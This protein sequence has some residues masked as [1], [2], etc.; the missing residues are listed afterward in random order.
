MDTELLS[1]LF[2]AFLFIGVIVAFR[3]RGQINELVQKVMHLESLLDL[4]TK[5]IEGLKQKIKELTSSQVVSTSF[6]QEALAEE[7]EPS[8]EKQK[9]SA[10]KQAPQTETLKEQKTV[11]E[12]KDTPLQ[13]TTPESENNEHSNP[14]KNRAAMHAKSEREERLIQ[15][16][17]EYRQDSKP[18]LFDFDTLVKGNG[19]FWLGAIVLAIG[20]VFLAKYSIEA[21]LL[22]PIVRVVLGAIFGCSLVVVAEVLNQNKEKFKI[23]T[24]YI[25]AALASGGVIT[26][27]AMILVS[28]DFYDFITPNI[29]FALLAIVSIAATY[30]ALRFGPVL[31]AIGIIGAYAV[32][33]LVST[34]SNNVIA[35][36]T[37]V[38][39]VS[40][41]AV[42]VAQLVKQKWLWWQSFVGH[43]V[44]FFA[45]V[46]MGGKDDFSIVLLY[47]LFS[48]YLFAL[49]SILGWKL[50]QTVELALSLKEL[51]A[52]KKELVTIIATLLLMAVN[53]SIHQEFT[54]IV[55][56]SLV[57]S[58]VIM[59]AT[60]RH[61]DLDHWPYLALGF[62]IFGFNLFS[63]YIDFSDNLFP[64]SGKYL[65]IQLSVLIAM[66]FSLQMIKRYPQRHAFLLLL[67][68]AP[69]SL[70]GV[71]YI[72]A[73]PSAEQFLYPVW[74]LEMLLIAIVASYSAMKTQTKL[75]QVTYL[76]LANAMLTMC[77][78]MLLSASTLTLALAVQVA[79]MS[80]LS[81]KYKV[82]LPDWLYKVALLVVVTRLTLAP[83]LAEYK[84]EF[85]FSVHWTLIV[86][87]AVLTVIWLATKYNPS[88]QLNTWFKGVL[89]HI[90][91]L[92]VTTETS[93]VLT[94]SY[95]DF[96][97]LAYH[98]AVLLALNWL[99]LSA[100]YFWRSRLSVSM[101]PLY[102][103]AGKALFV[104][105]ALIHFDISLV[106]SPF[107]YQHFVGD[108]MVNWLIPQWVL[109]VVVLLS[110]FKFEL[111]ETKYEK[112]I[113]AIAAT[114]SFF[115]INGEIRNVFNQGYLFWQ[116]PMQQAE[117][118]TYSIVW[119]L[120]STIVIYIGQKFEK[121]KLTNLGFIVL[122]L[123]VLK[124]FSVDMSHLEGLLR[125]LSFIGL[126]LALVAIGWLFQKMKVRS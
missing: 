121:S 120:V 28:F 39:F 14:W 40:L 107:I 33:I 112:A 76:V 78:T 4:K 44:W 52:P 77:L 61:R 114:F 122:A 72:M 104:G 21:G 3:G 31:A 94:G 6:E 47:A 19:I 90:I 25:P 45:A 95:P 46:A 1:F 48:I 82:Q 106:N 102:Q 27:F 67:V 59:V 9:P 41:S 15:S 98:E 115:F 50:T 8:A 57:I 37:Y 91:A 85:I 75:N 89:I 16:E 10:E 92:L 96:F 87:P 7:Q 97:N 111:I 64:F 34:G 79:S 84:D 22:P 65:F 53:L 101:K 49:T 30:L 74:A 88:K 113:F 83:W 20:G 110:M 18:A 29:A 12:F 36:L 26:C 118:Y 109:P 17:V 63:E 126:G 69:I 125:A 73:E 119:L 123:V 86:Y 81:W 71:S 43:F 2:N 100:V 13:Q 99:V 116:T 5:Q 103:I 93:Y 32:P 105:F 108:S 56:A 62:V 38:S 124:A 66:V 68:V 24:P 54:H 35:L 42:W 58:I 23:N 51:L 117:L 80:Y 70:F 11:L 60:Y 55:L